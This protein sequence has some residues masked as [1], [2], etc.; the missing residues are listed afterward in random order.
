MTDTASRGLA[1]V[2]CF[3][4][5]RRRALGRG[6]DI[7]RTCRDLGAWTHLGRIEILTNPSF[8]VPYPARA[9]L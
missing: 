4:T 5:D 1:F 8:L 9:S 2:C 3:T 7:Y 6:I